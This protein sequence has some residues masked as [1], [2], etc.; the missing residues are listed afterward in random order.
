[1]IVTIWRHGQAGH[2]TSDRQRQLTPAGREDIA[3]GCHRFARACRERELPLPSLVLHSS[4]V[5]TTQTAAILCRELG[6]VSQQPEHSL[7]P[8]TSGLSEVEGALSVLVAGSNGPDHLVL[9]SH[10]PLVSRL[11]DHFLGERGLAPSHTPGALVVLELAVPGP[12]CASLLFWALPPA[13]EVG[14]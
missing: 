9:V 2:A 14:R 6:D 8:G 10:Q 7:T 5:R 12:G 4:W 13:Y 1:M 3:L 11:T